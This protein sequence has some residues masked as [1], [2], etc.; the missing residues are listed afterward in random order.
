MEVRKINESS[1]H[2]HFFPEEHT[3]ICV[4]K[5][6][7]ESTE[8]L[9]KRFRKKF[10]KSNVIKELQEKMFFEKPGDKKRRKKEQNIRNIRQEQHKE[11]A[12]KKMRA[13]S[14]QSKI[15]KRIH[16]GKKND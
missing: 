8:S 16:K 6:R 15:N 14:L 9:I 10:S 5:R 7:G 1:Y 2:K 4:V 3:G 12:Q 11:L 13:K